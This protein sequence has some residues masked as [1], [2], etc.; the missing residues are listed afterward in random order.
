MTGFDSGDLPE[1]DGGVATL[2][3][4]PLA[5]DAEKAVESERAELRRE[6]D[7]IGDPHAPV[8]DL[9]REL[10]TATAER[11]RIAEE[12]DRTINRIR[13]ELRRAEVKCGNELERKRLLE[14][15]LAKKR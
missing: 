3:S 10:T 12:Y 5:S 9:V 15:R 2:D 4:I 1:L 13:D 8:A 11:K 6:I 14:L 7:A